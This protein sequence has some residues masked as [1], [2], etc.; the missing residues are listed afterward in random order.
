MTRTTESPLSCL[1]H[2]LPWVLVT[3]GGL[4]FV[5]GLSWRNLTSSDT[6]NPFFVIGGVLC[7]M[8][9]GAMSC[10]ADRVP[11]QDDKPPTQQPQPPQAQL[12]PPQ[13]EDSA[14]SEAREARIPF[15]S[16]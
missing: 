12:P 5:I 9:A 16:I 10:C 3:V 8:L 13:P 4:L 1:L 7:V 15:V 2:V 11:M 14:P 6:V